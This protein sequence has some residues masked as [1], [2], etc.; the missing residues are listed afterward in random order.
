MR[1]LFPGTIEVEFK[2]FLRKLLFVISQNIEMDN[3]DNKIHSLHSR[4][5]LVTP[6]VS[7]IILRRVVSRGSYRVLVNW[8][9]F[10]TITPLINYFHQAIDVFR[11]SEYF[12]YLKFRF[13][14]E[15]KGGQWWGRKMVGSW[16]TDDLV[17]YNYFTS[18]QV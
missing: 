12:I 15:S 17:V 14:I 5:C 2:W 1:P 3:Y 11:E 6:I 13:V 8:W 10:L 7:A 4:F 9:T 16:F 18:P